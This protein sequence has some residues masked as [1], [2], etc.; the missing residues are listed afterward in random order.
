MGLSIDNFP[1]TFNPFGFVVIF[2]EIARVKCFHD[3]GLINSDN[4]HI[5]VIV[6]TVHISINVLFFFHAD[7]AFLVTP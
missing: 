3:Y 5:S 1:G 4:N 2:L 7:L 6:G